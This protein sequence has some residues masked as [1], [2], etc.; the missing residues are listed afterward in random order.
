MQPDAQFVKAVLAGDNAA[1]ATLIARH[2]VSVRAVALNILGNHHDAQDVTQEAF[3]KAYQKLTTLRKADAFGPWV[4]KIAKRCALTAVRRAPKQVSIEQLGEI[5]SQSQNGQ[6]DKDDRELL[7]AL[8]KLPTAEEQVVMLRYFGGH[9][10]TAVAAIKG[11]SVGTVTKQL[12]RA[13]KRLKKIM[14]G[15]YRNGY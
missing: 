9:S 6:L 5:D 12:S 2:E 13:H 15:R 1:F 7:D 11:R 8:T 4:Q 14:E 10:V 3:I